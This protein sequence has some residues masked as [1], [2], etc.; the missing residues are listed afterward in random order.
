MR[1][2]VLALFQAQFYKRKCMAQADTSTENHEK[3]LVLSSLHC[4]MWI[5]L[6]KQ[7][8]SC[9]FLVYAENKFHYLVVVV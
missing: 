9:N 7:P 6:F 1:N 4:K 2:G 3:W 5:I 8:F